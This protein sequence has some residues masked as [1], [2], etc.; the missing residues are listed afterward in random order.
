MAMNKKGWM[1]E[2]IAFVIIGFIAVSFFAVFIY[3]FGLINTKLTSGD[4]DTP[5]ANI[6]KISGQT[7]SYLNIGMN[8]LQ[9]I[10]AIL[11]IGY[12]LA[13]LIFAYFS[14]K[15]QLWMFVYFLMTI[16]IVIFSIYITNSY[17]SLKTNEVIG[18]TISGFGISNII[19]SYLPVWTS[20]IGILGIVLCLVG[21]YVRRNLDYE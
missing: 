16:I 19:M 15:H 9:L 1:I 4:L 21:N 3:G 18:S 12:A 6:S 14:S 17:D 20:I 7:F 10:T 13:T 5:E 2:L 8:R 11:L